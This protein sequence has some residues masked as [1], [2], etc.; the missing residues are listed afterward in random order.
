MIPRHESNTSFMA[1]HHSRSL[2]SPAGTDRSN[3]NVWFA[4][5]CAAPRAIWWPH[6]SSTLANDDDGKW[7]MRAAIFGHLGGPTR[8]RSS[9]E[10]CVGSVPDRR[11]NSRT[12]RLS[13][14][15]ALRSNPP[16]RRFRSEFF[17]TPCFVI[18]PDFFSTCRLYYAITT[19][20]TLN[21]LS[22][23]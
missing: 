5:C 13:A 8:P 4:A 10:M 6:S 9:L 17:D 2:K 7:R 16:K 12:V 18:R 1:A 20:R 3:V 11:A 19:L 22:V 15:R 14:C 23:R 21:L